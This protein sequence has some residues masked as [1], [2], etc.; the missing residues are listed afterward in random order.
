MTTHQYLARV[1]YHILQSAC[2]QKV[3]AGLASAFDAR[4][5]LQSTSES[6]GSWGA[7]YIVSSEICRWTTESC[8]SSAE[9]VPALIAVIAVRYAFAAASRLS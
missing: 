4:A 5:F 6:S 1:C 8:Q 7:R 9:D 3:L 2:G